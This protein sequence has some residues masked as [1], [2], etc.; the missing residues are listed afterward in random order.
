MKSYIVAKLCRDL[1]RTPPCLRPQLRI[2]GQR[3]HLSR[4][5]VEESAVVTQLAVPEELSQ[6]GERTQREC[7]VDEWLLPVECLDCGTTGQRIFSGVCIDDLRIQ[8]AHRS[9]A[10]SLPAIPAVQG[11]TENILTAGG[12]VAEI[13]P[14]AGMAQCVGE[15]LLDGLPGLARIDPGSSASSASIAGPIFT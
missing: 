13:K 8:L 10:L 4:P 12:V 11:L 7:L 1:A 5:R 15:R 9:Q 6:H 2:D 14:V 3:T